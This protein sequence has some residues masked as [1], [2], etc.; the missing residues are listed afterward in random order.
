ME[1][2]DE[3]SLGIQEIDDQHKH[4]LVIFSQ[5]ERAIRLQ[6]GWME[7]FYEVVDLKSFAKMHFE[8]EEALMRLYAYGESAAHAEEHR[9]FFIKLAEIEGR[10]LDGSVGSELLTFLCDWLKDHI[11]GS[12]KGYAEHI[13]SGA[14]LVRSSVARPMANSFKL[15]S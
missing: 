2:S 3:Y 8:I 1:W 4:L 13:L 15:A 14:P 6:R 12:D 5:I 11:Q 10:S 9:Y 7:I